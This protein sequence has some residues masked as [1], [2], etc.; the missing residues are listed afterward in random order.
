MGAARGVPRGD[1][2]GQG[3]GEEGED[4]MG[5]GMWYPV[6]RK[7]SS[8]VVRKLTVMLGDTKI[9][10]FCTIRRA[11]QM[12]GDSFPGDACRPLASLG[13][14]DAGLTPSPV[15]VLSL[16]RALQPRELT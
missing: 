12:P 1:A 2:G 15:T 5:A 11:C 7:T 10:L 16:H 8:N 9:K 14:Q 6:R 13:S 3:G 4:L